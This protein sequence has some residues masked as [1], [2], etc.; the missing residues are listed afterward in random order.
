[1]LSKRLEMVSLLLGRMMTPRPSVLYG[2][3]NASGALKTKIMKS[4]RNDP[5]TNQSRIRTLMGALLFPL[6]RAE[7]GSTILVSGTR[8]HPKYHR[9][10]SKF[11]GPYGT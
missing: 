9:G 11:R 10:W 8:F 7:H 4:R 5:I 6:G 1:M 2:T 3:I